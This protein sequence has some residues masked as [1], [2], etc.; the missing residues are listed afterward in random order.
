M[1]LVYDTS[2]KSDMCNI[3]DYKDNIIDIDFHQPLKNL[4]LKFV[5]VYFHSKVVAV[6]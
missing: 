3:I 5:K 4:N 2:V 1:N 6:S